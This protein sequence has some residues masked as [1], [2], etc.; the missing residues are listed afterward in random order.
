MLSTHKTMKTSASAAASS[1]PGTREKSESG[2]SGCQEKSAVHS[3]S[4]P[5]PNTNTTLKQYPIRSRKKM[6]LDA[7]KMSNSLTMRTLNLKARIAECGLQ[8]VPEE[9]PILDDLTATFWPRVA[10]TLTEIPQVSC[11]DGTI[12]DSVIGTHKPN[13]KL[14]VY[15]MLSLILVFAEL[16]VLAL[17]LQISSTSLSSRSTLVVAIGVVIVLDLIVSF[18]RA[19]VHKHKPDR[20]ALGASLLRKNH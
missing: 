15:R 19:D 16:T 14:L 7:K 18:L 13:Q 11:T 6:L 5:Q 12:T 9:H 1:T 4:D 2:K 17:C 10:P 20:I 8:S 3:I